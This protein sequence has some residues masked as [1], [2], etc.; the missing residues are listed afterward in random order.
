MPKEPA[1]KVIMFLVVLVIS[2]L[3]VIN[4][5]PERQLHDQAVLGLTLIGY[6]LAIVIRFMID[7]L[8][9]PKP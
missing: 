3:L 9:Q 7:M 6:V 1:L 5:I 2:I 4:Q 8:V